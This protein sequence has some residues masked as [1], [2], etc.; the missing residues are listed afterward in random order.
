MKKIILKVSTV[1]VLS[2]SVSSSFPVV[3]GAQLTESILT[4]SRWIEQGIEWKREIEQW[5]ADIKAVTEFRLDGNILDKFTE[6]NDLLGSYGLDMGDL[7]LDNPKSQIGVYAKALFD[8]Y[9]IFNDCS[10]DYFSDNQ[11]KI[12]KNKMVRNVQ[13]IATSHKLS[14]NMSGLLEKL[15]E[16]NTKL[17]DS[18]D[19]KSSQDI[20]AGI[21][22]VVSSME[23]IRIQYEMMSMR[24]QAKKEIEQRQLEQIE[25]RK[26]N[27]A[28]SFIDQDFL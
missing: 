17:K 15:N 1:L 2:T 27:N 7:D 10:Y 25:K 9:L 26:R 13:E 22:S 19:I 21:Q 24:N 14:K 20:T 28:A 4:L 5:E 11:K 3:D 8:S 23:A 18:E 6:L 12:C 16:L